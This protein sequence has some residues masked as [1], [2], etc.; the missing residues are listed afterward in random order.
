MRSTDSNTHEEMT[1]IGVLGPLRVTVGGT[2][3]VPTAGK[4]RQLL[5]LLT[6]RHGQILPVSTLME[7]IW[8][9]AIPRSGLTTLQ[10]YIMQLRRLIGTSLN[11]SGTTAKDVL[12]TSFNGYQL[13]LRAGTFDLREFERLAA[14]G[15]RELERGR[16]AEASGHL[17]DAL[18]LWRGPAL[19]DVPVGRVLSLEIIGMDEARMRVEEQRIVSELVM[20]RHA[21]LIPDLRMLVAQHPMNENLSALLMIAFQRMGAEWRALEVFRNLRQALSSELGVEP[22]HHLQKL[23]QALL[24]QAPEL[25]A[26]AGLRFTR[27]HPPLI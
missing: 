23:H 7:E 19:I 11:S 21:Q 16:A 18:A 27:S 6:L 26:I 5:A 17:R 3:L 24:T 1:N 4:P 12:A 13:N 9:D 8:G 22:S 15:D 20:G 10:T 2:S 14:A 25:P